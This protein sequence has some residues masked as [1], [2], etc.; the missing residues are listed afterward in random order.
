MQ[1]DDPHST[2]AK[3]QAFMYNTLAPIS[4]PRRRYRD[5]PQSITKRNSVLSR[6]TDP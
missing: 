4:T 5:T 6:T 3:T 1:K 2:L